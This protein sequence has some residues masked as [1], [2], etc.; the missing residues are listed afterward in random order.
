MAR[1]RKFAQ[2]HGHSDHWMCRRCWDAGFVGRRIGEP[3]AVASSPVLGC[4]FCGAITPAGAIPYAEP[5]R[6]ARLTCALRAAPKFD[7]VTEARDRLIEKVRAFRDAARAWS[8]GDYDD[9]ARAAGKAERELFAALAV[10]ERK[11]GG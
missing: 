1:I 11:A 2:R 6:S 3:A 4:C 9:A 7:S 8:D 5:D 10:Y